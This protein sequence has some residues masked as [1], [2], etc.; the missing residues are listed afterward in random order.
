MKN[1]KHQRV[2]H[3]SIFA[4][5]GIT[6][7]TSFRFFDFILKKSVKVSCTKDVFL[8]E[9]LDFSLETAVKMSS[10]LLVQRIVKTS[11][12]GYDKGRRRGEVFYY[13]PCPFFWKTIWQGNYEI[14]Q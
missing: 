6:N 11:D 2:F 7:P 12:K 4:S 13:Q 3:Y 14:P 9:D 5:K 1:S 8:Q 10:T